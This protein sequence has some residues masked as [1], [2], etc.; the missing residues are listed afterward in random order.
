LADKSG[1]SAYTVPGFE[2]GI[3]LLDDEWRIGR[4]DGPFPYRT[5]P[6][7]IYQAGELLICATPYACPEENI[8]FRYENPIVLHAD[9]CEPLSLF[10]LSIDEIR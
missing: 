9:H 6:E 4:N 3:G 10:P 5:N 8:G 2:H 7:H 1:F